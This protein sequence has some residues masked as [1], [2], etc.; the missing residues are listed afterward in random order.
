MPCLTYSGA[1]REEEEGINPLSTLCPS[2]SSLLG[3]ASQ[4]ATCCQF[5]TSSPLSFS[6]PNS[7]MAWGLPCHCLSVWHHPV[8]PCVAVCCAGWCRWH[9]ARMGGTAPC[10]AGRAPT[11]AAGR[12]AR[13]GEGLFQCASK[14]LSLNFNEPVIVACLL[15][16]NPSMW[17]QLQEGW[18][19]R[20]V[21]N[22][23][24]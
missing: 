3:I 7:V 16:V 18:L 2:D 19:S 9:L 1:C 13:S 8:T 21:M 10:H 6:C 15:T 20:V 11:P 12:E 23:L 22:A 4:F 14:E 5:H 17:Y 24:S